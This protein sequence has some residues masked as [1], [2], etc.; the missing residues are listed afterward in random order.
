MGCAREGAVV[1]VVPERG[2]VVQVVHLLGENGERVAAVLCQ[3]QWL[4]L[5]H[6][7][8]TLGKTS[9]IKTDRLI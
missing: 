1:W 6:H 8:I 7:V 3:Q 9:L 4:L 2:A 5:S